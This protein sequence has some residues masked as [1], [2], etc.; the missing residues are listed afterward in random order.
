MGLGLKVI[1]TSRS[2]QSPCRIFTVVSLDELLAASDYV[3]LHLPL[4]PQTRHMIGPRQLAQMRPTAY[5][6]NTARGG[7]IDAE[8][9]P[10]R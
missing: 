10:R 3:S 9:W 8:R 6:I 2:G 5:L 1:A 7:L 4:T